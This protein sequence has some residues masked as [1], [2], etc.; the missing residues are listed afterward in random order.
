M[1]ESQRP[2]SKRGK[3]PSRGHRGGGA[4]SLTSPEP[5]RPRRRRRIKLSRILF[6]GAATIVA[7]LVIASFALASIPGGVGQRASGGATGIVE[8]VGTPQLPMPTANHIDGQRLEYSTVPPTSGDHW[9]TPAFCG[10]YDRELPDEQIVHNMEHGNLIISYNL[11][12]QA[13][14]EELKQLVTN[15]SGWNLW[16]IARPYTKIP[17]GTVAMSAWGVLDSFQGINEDRIKTFFETYGGNQLSSET[18][19]LRRGIPCTT[20][21]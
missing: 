13:K 19:R 10:F 9:S 1:P 14:V 4:G 11:P 5:L 2:R 6:I 18:A 3:R 12:D 8:G 15:L 20:A 17:E 21:G 16:G 7:I